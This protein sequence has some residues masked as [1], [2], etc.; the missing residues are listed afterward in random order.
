MLT[1]TAEAVRISVRSLDAGWAKDM[2]MRS[3]PID[4]FFFFFFEV[5]GNLIQR[6]IM[7]RHVGVTGVVW[8]CVGEDR[9]VL[10]VCFLY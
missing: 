8:L 9:V 10:C 5:W 1:V 7:I 3:G 2:M 6:F 4:F